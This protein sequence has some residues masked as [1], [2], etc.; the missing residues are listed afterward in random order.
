MKFDANEI[1]KSALQELEKRKKK[2]QEYLSSGDDRLL[3]KMDDSTKALL[4]YEVGKNDPK[5]ESFMDDVSSSKD[6]GDA[7]FI[8]QTAKAVAMLNSIRGE[9][10]STWLQNRMEQTAAINDVR[11][12][13][14]RGE[15]AGEYDKES[16]YLM[17]KDFWIQEI[18]PTII[19][20]APSMAA[21]ALSGV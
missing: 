6:V 7:I 12:M 2:V 17:D 20:N 18:A 8:S 11:G 1:N 16:I 5:N 14:R 13:I 4:A 21:A 9:Y 10:G 15:F 19:G 3:I